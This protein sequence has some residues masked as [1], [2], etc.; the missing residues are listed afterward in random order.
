MIYVCLAP[1]FLTQFWGQNQFEADAAPGSFHVGKVDCSFPP[2]FLVNASKHKSYYIQVFNLLL[3]KINK[4]EISFCH[5]QP[6]TH[7]E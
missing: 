4:V 1:F 3:I 7:L 5:T 6:N 2:Y